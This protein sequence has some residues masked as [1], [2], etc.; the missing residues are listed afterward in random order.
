M[1]NYWEA[2]YNAG[3]A[4]KPRASNATPSYVVNK[5]EGRRGILRTREPGK[6]LPST[7]HVVALWP[8]SQSAQPGACRFVGCVLNWSDVVA[9]GERANEL[10]FDSRPLKAVRTNVVERRRRGRAYVGENIFGSH[11][12]LTRR[13]AHW[14]LPHT[15]LQSDV[16][17]IGSFR[18]CA[19]LFVTA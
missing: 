16:I 5:D 1:R 3:S 11:E 14:Y 15:P 19:R 7:L 12:W 6:L 8:N 10:P 18:G 13:V 4:C 2:L 17:P 9:R